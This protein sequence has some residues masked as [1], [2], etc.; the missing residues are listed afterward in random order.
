MDWY[1][2]N[3]DVVKRYRTGNI[4]VNSKRNEGCLLPK[5]RFLLYL[6]RT[7]S[8]RTEREETCLR[9]ETFV[10]LKLKRNNSIGGELYVVKDVNILIQFLIQIFISPLPLHNHELLYSQYYN[11][12]KKHATDYLESVF[13]FIYL[14]YCRSFATERQTQTR[15]K[16][17]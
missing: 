5:M 13:Y 11:S 10:L 8:P 14:F 9:R 17:Y 2:L 4:I 12:V 1:H 7:A 3:P 6:F 15:V 16:S